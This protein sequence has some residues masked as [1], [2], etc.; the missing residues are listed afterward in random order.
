MNAENAYLLFTHYG[1]AADDNIAQMVEKVSFVCYLDF[2]RRVHFQEGTPSVDERNKL[3]KEAIKL[4]SV[5]VPQLLQS[6]NDAV[7]GK[8]VFDKLHRGICEDM[9]QIYKTVCMIF[10]NT[11]WMLITVGFRTSKLLGIISI[12]FLQQQ[13]CIMVKY[14]SAI[15]IVYFHHL[16]T[17]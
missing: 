14:A 17:V 1:I 13:L 6:A 9:K 15:M 11:T 7:N 16:K 8:E 2:C 3:Q 10:L 4:L 12:N 5:R